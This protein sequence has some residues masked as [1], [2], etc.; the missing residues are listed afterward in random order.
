MPLPKR[1]RLVP[2]DNSPEIDTDIELTPQRK[3][4]LE[5]LAKKPVFYHPNGKTRNL[6]A[7]ERKSFLQEDEWTASV[8]L[9]SVECK[10]CGFNKAL[11]SRSSKGYDTTLWMKHRTRCQAIYAAWLKRN[12]ERDDTFDSKIAVP[13]SDIEMK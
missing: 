8:T 6:K 13:H 9:M 10:A 12:G 1:A 5:S 4:F 7:H 11:D 3:R 2:I